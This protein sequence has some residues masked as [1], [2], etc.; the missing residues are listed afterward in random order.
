M[1][2]PDK[3]THRF[4]D[5]TLA[6]KGRS[7]IEWARLSRYGRVHAITGVVIRWNFHGGTWERPDVTFVALCGPQRHQVIPAPCHDP[8]DRCL[9]CDGGAARQGVA[10]P[11]ALEPW[12]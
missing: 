4:R 2:A 8:L 6:T 7:R 5:G 10:W 3:A 9:R 12:S 1:A 11:R